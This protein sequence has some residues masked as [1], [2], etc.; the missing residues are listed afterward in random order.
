M[1]KYIKLDDTERELLEKIMDV[2]EAAQVSPQ[3]G[4]RVLL[5]AAGASIGL[6]DGSLMSDHALGAYAS[7][8][9]VAANR[10]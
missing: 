9:Q 10:H 7:G 2:F 3:S 1:S 5:W 4:E 8:W 6:R